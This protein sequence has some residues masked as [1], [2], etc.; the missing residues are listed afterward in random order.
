MGVFVQKV[1]LDFTDDFV[2]LYLHDT[3]ESTEESHT[4]LFP[5]FLTTRVRIQKK[6]SKIRS[7]SSMYENGVIKD[8]DLLSAYL[9]F[10]LSRA[11]LG[12]FA[13]ARIDLLCS[14]PT[15][16]LKTTKQIW[17]SIFEH[18]GISKVTFV[19]HAIAGAVGAGYSFPISTVAVI[20]HLGKSSSE[21]AAVSLHECLFCS[22]LMFT[23]RFLSDQ[24]RSQHFLATRQE[25]SSKEWKYIE[26]SI[27]GL[28]SPD[29]RKKKLNDS[30]VEMIIDSGKDLLNDIQAAL[31][32][33]SVE[34][35]SLCSSQGIVLT[36]ELA[37]QEGIAQFLSRT[38]M[39]PVYSASDPEMACLRGMSELIAFTEQTDTLS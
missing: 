25:I 22:Q 26:S 32:R 37:A 9:R 29:E 36:G 6:N 16:T 4:K 17:S 35:L 14:V 19:S 34:E 30:F 3:K 18:I 15:L 10:L 8:S 31:E 13:F 28:L 11:G 12:K 23:G 7:F 38:L 5:E 20:A 39:I 27:G 1:A 33:L 24:A 21:I 2:R